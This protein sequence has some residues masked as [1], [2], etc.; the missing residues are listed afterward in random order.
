MAFISFWLLKKKKVSC[1][2]FFG[3]NALIIAHDFRGCIFGDTGREGIGGGGGGGGRRRR[4]KIKSE[5]ITAGIKVA[6]DK[7]A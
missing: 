6:V 3:P 4:Q 1:V 7:V 5:E 2:L